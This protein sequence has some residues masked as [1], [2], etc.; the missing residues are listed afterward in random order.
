M[1]SADPQ[2][3]FSL[4]E[5]N[6]LIPRLEEHFQNFWG[7]RQNAQNILQKLRKSLKEPQEQAPRDIADQQM[8]TS[9]AHFL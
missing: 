7:M 3:F 9:Q 2:H 5:V 6:A 4:E 8:R 1:E